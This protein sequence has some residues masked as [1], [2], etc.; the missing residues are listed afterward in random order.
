MYA[1]DQRLGK[2]VKVRY[3][4]GRGLPWTGIGPFLSSMERRFVRWVWAIMDIM[5][6]LMMVPK[7][8]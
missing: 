7:N 3:D 8:V 1:N 5:L 6:N 2:R 4:Q